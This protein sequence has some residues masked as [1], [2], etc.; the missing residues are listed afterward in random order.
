MSQKKE[1]NDFDIFIANSIFPEA[2]SIFTLN[3]KSLKEI[4]DYCY[5][6]V[7]TNALLIPYTTGKQSLEQIKNIYRSL[8]AENRLIIPGQVARE[9]AKNRTNKLLEV[10]QQLSRKRNL[11]L[12]VS[13]Y[14]L[15]EQ[16]AQ[17]QEIKELEETISKALKNYRNKIG[18][19]LDEIYEWNWND[20]VS[21]I[22]NELFSIN[23]VVFDLPID[24]E[25]LE[26]DLKKRQLHSILPGYKDSSKEDKGIG[27]L[28]IWHTIL[29]IGKT[30]ERSVI[31][32][33]GDEKTDWWHRSDNQPIYPRYELV[34]EFNRCSKGKSFYIISFSQFLEL[35]EASEPVIEEIK[36]NEQ[37]GVLNQIKETVPISQENIE[38]KV[39]DW[40]INRYQAHG[41]K[42]KFNVLIFNY[43][44]SFLNQ[45]KYG[46]LVRKVNN[47]ADLIRCL[48]ITQSLSMSTLVDKVIL[49]LVCGDLESANIAVDRVS[50]LDLKRNFSIEV[51]YVS[52]ENS[53][54]HLYRKES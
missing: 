6:V 21:R 17:Y 45:A 18:E 23:N 31:F 35:Y 52:S 29:E 43:I 20:P 25:K 9:F 36:N 28:L 37:R 1:D 11:N 30:F 40:I 51:G 14:P 50:Y 13:S 22:Y 8:V 44:V 32:I 47:H 5:I 7:D 24:R 41:P 2:N 46:I 53:F 49:I 33:S 26:N 27:D 54:C 38:E 4:K 19:I 10:Y 39:L 3:I 12:T 48:S 42:I 15:L 34:N 16:L